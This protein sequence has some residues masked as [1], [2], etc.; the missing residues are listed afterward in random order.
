MGV[1]K[2]RSWYPQT[3]S[4]LS[5]VPTRYTM[6]MQAVSDL[7]CVHGTGLHAGQQAV[8]CV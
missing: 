8:H 2:R 5:H 7:W 1:L 6:A 3:A 4:V